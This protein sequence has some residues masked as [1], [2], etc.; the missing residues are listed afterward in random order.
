MMQEILKFDTY[1]IIWTARTRIK[2]HSKHLNWIY[3]RWFCLQQRCITEFCDE[4][5]ANRCTEDW[6]VTSL[7]FGF[8]HT[9]ANVFCISVSC[10]VVISRLFY[11]PFLDPHYVNEEVRKRN[12]VS[13]V[14]L[15]VTR[16]WY[17]RILEQ[18]SK[19]YG[20]RPNIT[21]VYYAMML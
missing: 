12:G 18:D 20:W 6:R 3:C 2:H 14:F 17:P 15:F 10:A 13:A 16:Q 7:F 5:Y 19:Y 21:I 8:C 11:V 1:I 4:S 9:S